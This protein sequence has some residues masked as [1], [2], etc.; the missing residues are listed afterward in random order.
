MSV[1][2]KAWTKAPGAKLD[3]SVDWTD[4]LADGETISNVSWTVPSGLT[5]TTEGISGGICTAW[6]MGGTL[7]TLYIVVCTIT[8]NVGRVDSR[9]LYITVA[10][11]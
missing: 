2:D 11:R 1:A 8:T 4:W 10:N 6:L 3:Y 5:K 7:G 9:S